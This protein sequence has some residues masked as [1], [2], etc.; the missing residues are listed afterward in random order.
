M[1]MISHLVLI[2]LWVSPSSFQSHLDIV[3]LF[4]DSNRSN[5]GVEILPPVSIASSIARV[6]PVTSVT[7]FGGLVDA[8]DFRCVGWL[9]LLLKLKNCLIWSLW[10][11]ALTKGLT[12]RVT[13]NEGRWRWRKRSKE[14]TLCCGQDLNPLTLSPEL[15]T[16]IAR[17]RRPANTEI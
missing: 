17:P 5:P 11:I 2:Y 8:L 15:S 16:L 13:W 12:N 7:S 3:H 1:S 6:A 9:L 4:L 10:K 14:K